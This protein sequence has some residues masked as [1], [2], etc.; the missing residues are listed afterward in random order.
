MRERESPKKCRLASVVEE[1]E[2]IYAKKKP[3]PA[4]VE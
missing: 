3:D 2:F 1:K 4:S